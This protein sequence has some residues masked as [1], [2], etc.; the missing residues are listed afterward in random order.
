MCPKRHHQG[1][2]ETLRC[3]DPDSGV[4]EG[5]VTEVVVGGECQVDSVK[6]GNTTV[7]GGGLSRGERDEQREISFRHTYVWLVRIFLWPPSGKKIQ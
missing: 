3:K 6:E 4:E 7:R 1:G 5:G 2:G